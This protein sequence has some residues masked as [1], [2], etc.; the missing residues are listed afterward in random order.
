MDYLSSINWLGIGYALALI[1]I[2][3]TVAKRVSRLAERSVNKRFSKHQAVLARR[4]VFYVLIFIF[5]FS[6]LQ[7]LG[8]KLTV[9]LGAAG[10]FTV[11]LSFASQTAAS[12]LVSGI[13]LIFECPFKVG[14]TIKIKDTVGTVES[15][16][17]LST[18]IQTPDNM[19]VRIPNETVVK[20]EII[21]MS[22]FKIR[23]I[24]LVIGVS[25]DSNIDLVKKIL[26]DIADKHADVLGDPAPQ[27]IINT[28]ADS[29]IEIKFMT[30]AAT[31][32]LA[33]VRNQLNDEIKKQF[34]T[35]QIEM[36]FP[37]MTLHRAS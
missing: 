10:V 13:F 9:L 7:Q 5:A 34:D 22:Y 14:D 33:A 15:M 20:S 2:G 16:D 28:F 31:K 6:A 36:P 24:D 25:Y 18:Q 37:Q 11:A 12:N 3:F 4:L 21:N 35:N 23:R 26:L 29:A 19:R 8:F 30:W 27:V 17:L 32:H 1:I